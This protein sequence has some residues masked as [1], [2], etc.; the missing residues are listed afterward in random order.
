M[1]K[2]YNHLTEQDRIFLSQML[3]QG[4]TKAKIAK[5]L[6][7]HRSTVYREINRNIFIPN[8]SEQRLYH[9]WYAHRE[10]LD[11]RKRNLK[12][13]KDEKLCVEVKEK[14][15]Q[16]WSPW[17]IEGRLKRENCGKSPITHESIYRYI[18]SDPSIRNQY[19]K[20]LRRKHFCR[21]RR[22]QRKH[23]FPQEMLI[24]SRPE[25]IRDRHEFGHWECDLMMFKQGIKGNLITLRERKTRFLIAIKNENKKART[26][27]LSLISTISKLKNQVKSITFD[28]G[29]EFMNYEWIKDCIGSDIYF[30]EPA[31]PYQKGSIENGNGI[32]RVDFPRD[33]NISELKQKE[34]NKVINNINERPLKCLDY[35]TPKELFKRYCEILS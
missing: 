6:G 7:V 28:Q 10:Y 30:C 34:I 2:G 17:Q 32:I 29:S 9:S 1:A 24:N 33:L 23:R 25:Q 8:Y 14:L 22:H 26:T 15:A 27:A 35:Q 19:Y 13:A 21:I 31:S 3:R 20:K 11:R 18:Y 5:I 4:Y 16:G 12:L